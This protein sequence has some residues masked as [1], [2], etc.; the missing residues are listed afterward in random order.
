M[1]H[2]IQ[3]AWQRDE[4]E[5]YLIYAKQRMGKS[6]YSLQ[7]LADLFDGDWDQAM[8]SMVFKLNDLINILEKA[9]REHNK[10][11]SLIWDDAGVFGSKYL[12]QSDRAMVMHLQSLFDVI[13]VSTASLILTTPNPLGL[14]RVI[15]M[16]EWA[17][18]KIYR[19]DPYNGRLA[20]GYSSSMLPSGMRLIHRDFSDRFNVM[21]PNDVYSRYSVIR[22][23]YLDMAI[24]KLKE[25]SDKAYP[26]D[27]HDDGQD[28]VIDE[29][30]ETVL[31]N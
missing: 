3:R 7:V 19:R 12:Y 30:L 10:L 16:Y 21:L 15:R 29:E 28:E 23:G 27:G 4:F 14:L 17:R 5:G 2:A 31:K 6:S 8:S 13:G 11:K 1:S 22:K 24:A 26:D 20:V 18:V 9:Q 25:V